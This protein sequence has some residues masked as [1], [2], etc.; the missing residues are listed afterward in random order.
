MRILPATVVT[1]ACALSALAPARAGVFSVA[2]PWTRAASANASA[3]A[4]MELM[5]S[6]GAT[7]VDVRSPVA[8]QVRLVTGK[9]RQAPPFA[10]A[11]PARVTVKLAP[12]NVRLVLERVKRPLKLKDRVPL[13]LV[14]RNADG[15]TQE[16]EVDAEVRRRSPSADHHVK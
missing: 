6:D 16:V 1:L 10:L 13:T 12:G 11:L 15:S 3:E 14:L 2:E 5:S 4:F 9:Q 8:A 7:L